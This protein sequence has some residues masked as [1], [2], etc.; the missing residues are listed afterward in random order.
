MIPP[1][2]PLILI[3]T[4]TATSVQVSVD[5]GLRTNMASPYIIDTRT[6]T[7]GTHLVHVWAWQNETLAG[8]RTFT[9][10]VDPTSTWPPDTASMDIVL[11]GF[12]VNTSAM[13]D[14]LISRY[15]API[16]LSSN[17]FTLYNFDLRFPFTIRTASNAYFH[18][19]LNATRGN[20]TF[21]TTLEGR[22]NLSALIAQRND[23]VARDIFD[24]LVG[25]QIRSEWFESYVAA[26]A[27]LA[28]PVHRGFTF[29]LVNFSAL[30][31]PGNGTDHWFTRRT[32]DPDTGL[33]ENWWRLEW[34]N[35][36]NTPMGY[37]MN[38]FGGPNR[39]V[40]I[41]PTAYEWYTDWAY[42]WRDGGN[43][44]APYS[45][46]YQEVSPANRSVYLGELVNDLVAG[47]GS[48]LPW[49]PPPE[50]NIEL[51]TYVLSGSANYTVDSL[52]WVYSDQRLQTYLQQ[53]YV[54]QN[55]W[56][57]N[58]TFARVAD[59][60]G[61]R[62]AVD[63][64]TVYIGGHGQ[65]NGSNIWDYLS[66]HRSD[67]ATDLSGVFQVLSVVL[68]YDNRTMVFGGRPFTGLGGQEVSLIALPTDRL[69]YANG[70][71]EKGITSYLAHEIGHSL[72][73]AHQFGPHY[74][75]DFVDGNMGYFR[76]ELGYGAFW[77]DAMYRVL[78]TAKLLDT[79]TSLSAKDPINL[80]P[81]F[82]EVYRLYASLDLSGA[83]S[84][85]LRLQDELADTVPP[86][87]SAGPDRTVEHGVSLVLTGN[88][89]TDNYRVVN[90]SWDFGDGTNAWSWDP[91]ISHTW[92][93][94]GTYRVTLTVFDAAGNRGS[95]TVT[96]MVLGPPPPG[97][98]T[99][100]ALVG[101]VGLV[102]AAAAGVA[103]IVLLRRRRGQS[104][105]PQT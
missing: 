23:G 92:P 100:W 79:V 68:L 17:A 59:Y 71:R 103:G 78:A 60:P 102:V 74:R 33:D 82:S 8:S 38:I 14:D 80:A 93:W 83:Y 6:W 52:R 53:S 42:V 21:T 86:I 18:A 16:R 62:A 7:N 12:D 24:P 4:G 69:F 73:Y 58:T 36:L 39:M 91:T 105:P 72:G 22:L 67:F 99:N 28:P 40:V 15:V 34:D 29:Y 11:V 44:R 31:N 84:A 45:Q 32:P 85:V 64:N 2:Y 65:L 25:Y 27:P 54:P 104:P 97:G 9:I 50:R 63:A 90:Y 101:G 87:A 98:P 10:F 94:G 30:D 95:A 96:V 70:T 3:L 13:A 76:N 81:E 46:R 51:R 88:R 5:T 57:V 20:A 19:L 89:S 55:T 56:I 1:G 47:L 43:G 49:A 41:D 48:V 37:P 61:L 66:I 77:T 75:S 35:S 26:H